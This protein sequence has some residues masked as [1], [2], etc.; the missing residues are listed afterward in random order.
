[1]ST[2]QD[3][4]INEII[5]GVLRLKLPLPFRGLDH[6]YSFLLQDRHGWVVVDTGFGF[7]QSERIWKQVL[8]TVFDKAPITKLVVTHYHPDH[9]GM[10][11]WISKNHV[12]LEFMMSRTEWLLS[13]L[14]CLDRSIEY[15]QA[16]DRYYADC[17][18][19]KDLIVDIR[20]RRQELNKS[21]SPIPSSYTRLNDGDLLVIGD[22]EWQ[23][24][25][26][27]G[28]APEQV[29]L[30]CE[31]EKLLL[32]ADQIMAKITPNISVW[33]IEPYE[34]PVA[35]YMDSLERLNK[36]PEGSLVLPFHGNPIQ[37]LHQRIAELHEH[38][39]DRCQRILDYCRI[40]PRSTMDIC[41]HLFPKVDHP[42]AYL[43]ALGEA[44]AHVNFL[45]VENKL[46]SS[47]HN[48]T[49]IFSTYD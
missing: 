37:N 28:H 46:I 24:I 49:S 6:V 48:D 15:T 4:Q 18:V 44:R 5:P 33:P 21:I 29:M 19:P 16:T 45:T 41:Q 34:N 35:E 23:V 3:L 40:E 47:C 14:L 31:T 27:Q 20:Y 11:G 26:G 12:V 38:H 7:E 2:F 32:A 17:G 25:T 10:A 36:L 39:H 9:S 30:W 22:R 42:H 13:R 1:M 8:T 43:F